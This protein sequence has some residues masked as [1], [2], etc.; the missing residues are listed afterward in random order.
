[1]SMRLLHRLLG[2]STID[3]Q[4]ERAYRAGRL[5]AL[6]EEMAFTPELR[7]LLRAVEA[8]SFH[9][10]AQRAYEILWAAEQP[11]GGG[12]FPWPAEGLPRDGEKSETKRAA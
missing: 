12:G 4:I 9:E 1:M 6:L 11:D 2:R 5:D 7:E 3:P 8:G 10:F